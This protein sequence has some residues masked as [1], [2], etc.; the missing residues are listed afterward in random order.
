MT[1]TERTP[2][3]TLGDR[4]SKAR[5]VAGFNRAEMALA[6]GASRESVRRWEDDDFVPRKHVIIAWAKVTDVDLGWLDP[7]PTSPGGGS[8]EQIHGS[9]WNF[10][11]LRAA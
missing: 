4:L 1:T 5:R 8:G 6:I 3:W 7:G 9:C 10:A 2:R 11:A